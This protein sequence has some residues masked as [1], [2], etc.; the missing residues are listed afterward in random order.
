M[1]GDKTFSDTKAP[2]NMAISTLESLRSLLDEISKI[3]RTPT[4]LMSDAEKQN[5]KI[6]LVKRFYTNS[7]PLLAE[8]VVDKYKEILDIK[9]PQYLMTNNKIPTGNKQIRF[10]FELDSKL[11]QYLINIQRELQRERYF[12]PPKRDRGKAVAEF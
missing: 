1:E 12:M 6:R 9:S 8:T 5:I 2:F 7:S 4:F 10:D 3:E 11:D